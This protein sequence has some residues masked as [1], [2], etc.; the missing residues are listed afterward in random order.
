MAGVFEIIVR[1]GGRL[2]LV[3][4]GI[5]VIVI[6]PLRACVKVAGVVGPVQL[7]NELG[8]HSEQVIPVQVGKERML[9]DLRGAACRAQSLHWIVCEQAGDERPGLVR[10]KYELVVRLGPHDL[11]ADHIREELLGRVA[12]EGRHARQELVQNDAHG[13]PV[14][15][16]AVPLPQDDLGREVLRCAADLLVVELLAVV[17]LHKRVVVLLEKVGRQIHEANFGQAKVG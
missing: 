17:V 1:I 3:L 2:V 4:V 14:H 9:F 13:P 12:V 15:R 6:V 7:R 16:F 5:S 11:A 10:N 8:L